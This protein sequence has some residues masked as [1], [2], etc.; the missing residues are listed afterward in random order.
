MAMKVSTAVLSHAAQLLRIQHQQ[1]QIRA[2]EEH[3]RQEH[4]HLE[5][6]REAK[7]RQDQVR[8]ANVDITV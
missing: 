8:G 7:N 6:L 4:M 5:R 1:Q 3:I 2:Q